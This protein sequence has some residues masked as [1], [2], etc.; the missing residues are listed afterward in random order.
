MK[1]GKIMCVDGRTFQIGAVTKEFP[2]VSK[3]W[4]CESIIIRSYVIMAILSI[5]LFV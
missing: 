1:A 3:I 2:N 5:A 4:L